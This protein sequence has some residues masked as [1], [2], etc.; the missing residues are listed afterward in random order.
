MSKLKLRPPTNKIELR[1]AWLW[2]IQSLVIGVVLLAASISAYVIWEDQRWWLWIIIA[3]FAGMTLIY[4]VVEPWLRYRIH[5][6]EVS[7]EA[8][9]S[10]TGWVVREWR[11]APISRIQTVDAVRGPMEQVFGL[12]TLRIT[13]ASSKGAIE[14]RGLDKSVAAKVAEELTVVTEKTPGDAT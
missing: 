9:Y 14:I 11:V 2:F 13:T 7:D 6:W 10:L 5:R 3:G 4:A 8:V 1:A 12:S